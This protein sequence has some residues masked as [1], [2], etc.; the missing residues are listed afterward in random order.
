MGACLF[1]NEGSDKGWALGYL[2]S[3]ITEEV[4]GVLKLSYYNGAKCPSGKS[5]TVNIFFQCEKGSGPV[6]VQ[7]ESLIFV[8]YVHV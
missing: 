7:L 1:P 6:S 8:L 4:S 3:D 5:H 2:L